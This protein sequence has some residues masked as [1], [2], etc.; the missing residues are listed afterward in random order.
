ML[1]A[2]SSYITFP[3]GIDLQFQFPDGRFLL[4]SLADI[5]ALAGFGSYRFPLTHEKQCPPGTKITAT[6]SDST[7]AQAQAVPLLLEGAYY[8]HIRGTN[9]TPKLESSLPRFVRGANQNIM[10]PCWA[11]GEGPSTPVGFVDSPPWV[12]ASKVYPIDVGALT[13]KRQTAI[14]QIENGI[15]FEVRNLWFKVFPDAR[16]SGV[17]MANVRGSSGYALTDDYILTNILNGVPL[18]KDWI[19]RSGESI[20]VDFELV[21]FAGTGNVNIQVFANGVKRRPA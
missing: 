3:V 1:R 10:A 16:A 21:D 20:I 19:I 9:P 14:L 2:I 18:P 7:P 15:E 6:F 17:C 4:H 8:Y 13:E 5:R 11:L 12:Y